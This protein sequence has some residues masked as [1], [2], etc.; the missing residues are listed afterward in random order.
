MSGS[1]QKMCIRILFELANVVCIALFILGLPT[2]AYN[3]A[4]HL[5]SILHERGANQ[6]PLV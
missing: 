4:F 5:C 6:Q 2:L 3:Y 1:D